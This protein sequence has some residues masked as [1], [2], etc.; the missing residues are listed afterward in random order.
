MGTIINLTGQY[1]VQIVEISQ[2]IATAPNFHETRQQVL[3]TSAFVGSKTPKSAPTRKLL[4]PDGHLGGLS[5][6][7][8]RKRQTVP[9]MGSLI[10]SCECVPQLTVDVLP[11]GVD[12][13]SSIPRN[14]EF[15]PHIFDDSVPKLP[16]DLNGF[17]AWDRG[18]SKAGILRKLISTSPSTMK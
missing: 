12:V 3:Q 15:L 9:S 2:P 17:E 11:S 18:S 5:L 10:C 8:Q 1:G 6:T 14:V 4:F 7:L 16:A 13:I